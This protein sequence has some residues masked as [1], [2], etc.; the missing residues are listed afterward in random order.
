MTRT[1][2]RL[3][4]SAACAL[5]ACAGPVYFLEDRAKFGYLAGGLAAALI[6]WG[7]LLMASAAEAEVS[8]AMQGVMGAGAAAVSWATISLVA[9]FEIIPHAA[10][11][12]LARFDPVWMLGGLA[13]LTIFGVAG[14]RW[15]REKTPYLQALL[16]A[17]FRFSVP[18]FGLELVARLGGL[19]KQFRW[20][21][22]F[23][24]IMFLVLD[25]LGA[26]GDLPFLPRKDGRPEH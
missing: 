24:G 5:A 23:T 9:T 8:P 6:A 11:H 22:L 19:P 4:L 17:L 21:F 3:S 18:L 16:S 14:W 7:L 12:G 26:G 1:Y 15:V 2:Y 10:R 13:P 25:G 20:L